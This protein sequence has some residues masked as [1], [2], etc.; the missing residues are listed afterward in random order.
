MMRKAVTDIFILDPVHPGGATAA[1]AASALTRGG[2]RREKGRGAR[3][4]F[5]VRVRPGFAFHFIESGLPGLRDALIG[6]LGKQCKP[7]IETALEGRSVDFPVNDG[8]GADESH[9]VLTPFHNALGDVEGMVLSCGSGAG[10]NDA[11]VPVDPDPDVVDAANTPN[12]PAARASASSAMA[13]PTG[14]SVEPSRA[15]SVGVVATASG[16]EAGALMRDQLLAVVSHELRAPLAGIQSWAHVL[17]QMVQKGRKGENAEASADASHAMQG[18]SHQAEGNTTLDRVQTDRALAGITAGVARQA[19]M[20]DTLI[21]AARV[22]SGDVVLNRRVFLLGEAV[23]AAL[24]QWQGVA[25]RAQVHVIRSLEWV[26][27]DAAT[28]LAVTTFTAAGGHPVAR[29]NAHT[30]RVADTEND[31]SDLPRD[32]L[33][34]DEM[35]AVVP[36]REAGDWQQI[37]GDVDRVTQVIGNVLSNAIKFNVPG[38]IIRIRIGWIA[39]DDGIDTRDDNDN[40]NGNRAP[41]GSMPGTVTLTIADS[42]VGID[43]ATL[44]GIFHRFSQADSSTTRHH[45]GLGLGLA[46]A[47]KLM[48]MHDG[49]IEARSDGAAAG[50][51]FTLSFPGAVSGSGRPQPVS[52]HP[53]R[54]AGG[55]PLS[56]HDSRFGA[57]PSL[58]GVSIMVIDDQREARESLAAVLEQSGADVFP[59]ASARDAIAELDA[60]GADH[61]P[62]VLICDIAMPDEDGYAT[63]MRIREWERAHGV[64][65]GHRLAAIAVTAFAE[66]EDKERALARGYALHFAKPVD[67]T[68][69]LGAVAALTGK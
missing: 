21:D 51:T 1:P 58:A 57:L 2:A 26:E 62:D 25:E 34:S 7:S 44:P 31:S 4:R 30:S 35:A 42:G 12:V 60:R 29:V 69:L 46:V 19:E 41:A 52:G 48:Q 37:G 38:G 23:E 14:A 54:G 67:P 10:R 47:K 5:A 53:H 43:A 18:E 40:G 65:D 16:P 33:A 24:S 13:V 49:R 11:Q 55:A 32:V 28:A 20:V 9:A 61:E 66:R 50:A 36:S 68:R 17:K 64:L 3:P 63:L 27:G 8:Q 15:I 6:A 45:E 39:G 56:R 59:A 22:L